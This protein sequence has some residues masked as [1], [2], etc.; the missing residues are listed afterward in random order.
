MVTARSPQRVVFFD[1]AG[2]GVIP[3]EE[4]SYYALRHAA[5]LGAVTFTFDA[6]SPITPTADPICVKG[7]EL[8]GGAGGTLVGAW[9]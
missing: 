6:L 7:D 9:P 4:G 8:T 5:D 2:L 3:A 1:N